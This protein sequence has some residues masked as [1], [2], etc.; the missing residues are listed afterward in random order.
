MLDRRFNALLLA[1]A[2]ALWSCA[3]APPA[4]L[5]IRPDCLEDTICNN[6][7]WVILEVDIAPSGVV[8]NAE[9]VEVC[10]DD[11]FNRSTINQVQKWKWR[12]SAEG[13]PDHLIILCRP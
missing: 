7:G 1:A 2:A 8:E 6:R 4:R 9:V 11:S 10:P 3:Q 5:P 13:L 12:P